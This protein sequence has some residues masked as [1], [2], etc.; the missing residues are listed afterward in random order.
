M[1]EQRLPQ[2]ILPPPWQLYID[3][4]DDK[5][6]RRKRLDIL[7][8]LPAY[9]LFPFQ[10]T[11]IN[12]TVAW[13]VRLG[14]RRQ[15][16]GDKIASYAYILLDHDDVQPPVVFSDEFTGSQGELRS[17]PRSAS[18]LL[19]RAQDLKEPF[20]FLQH[21]PAD[22]VENIRGM[23]C[24]LIAYYS[25][26]AGV[27]DCAIQWHQFYPSLLDALDY[28]GAWMG[29]KSLIQEDVDNT[30]SSVDFDDQI[31]TPESRLGV[32]AKSAPTDS[33]LEVSTAG[34]QPPQAM[35]E[36]KKQGGVVRAAGSSIDAGPDTSLGKIMGWLGS[37]VR[38]L[39]NL[40]KTPVTITRQSLYPAYW[41]YRLH[42][43][44]HRCNTPHGSLSNVYVYY[45]RQRRPKPSIMVHADE[46]GEIIPRTFEGIQGINLC[47]PFIQLV[48]PKMKDKAYEWMRIRYLVQYYFAVAAH[49][50]LVE[51][52][53]IDLSYSAVQI[54]TTVCKSFNKNGDGPPMAGTDTPSAKISTNPL[55]RATRSMNNDTTGFTEDRNDIDSLDTP[56]L[57]HP[58]ESMKAAVGA[59]RSMVIQLRVNRDLLAQVVGL[60]SSA[61]ASAIESSESSSSPGNITG[62]GS[63]TP[64]Q[65][66]GLGV[67]GIQSP[68]TTE[69]TPRVDTS[70]LAVARNQIHVKDL[71]GSYQGNSIASPNI[72][73]VVRK[74]GNTC[75]G[76]EQ[77][78]L[79]T[80]SQSPSRVVGGRANFHPGHSGTIKFCKDEEAE[81]VIRGDVD[82]V[83]EVDAEPEVE[84]TLGA[85]QSSAV[86]GVKRKRK[87]IQGSDTSDSGLE[88]TDCKEWQRT[89]M[90]RS[91]TN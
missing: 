76:N 87:Q 63:H 68:V 62:S 54:F 71:N 30:I 36:N 49:D 58:E 66:Q 34:I 23:I 91:Q 31:K 90:R 13:K 81:S 17:Y 50:G 41:P 22:K 3:K 82:S 52:L 72:R 88:M 83:G 45:T 57:S 78:R 60:T 46:N 27:S 56:E 51:E 79:D 28:V 84:E 11:T 16:N 70:A 64:Y 73:S 39:D 15:S 89:V 44:T 74:F 20:C 33:L 6:R 29:T 38:S 12:N 18:S 19:R 40:P 86:R 2:S 65:R 10:Q 59:N 9:G 61:H 1:A 25:L 43:G 69:G 77:H 85:V 80:A 21:Y 75:D 5:L 26:I 35:G 24:S 7:Y 67:S 14:D 42:I 37:K 53:P 55:P 47:E 8:Q 32:K 48:Q 4:L